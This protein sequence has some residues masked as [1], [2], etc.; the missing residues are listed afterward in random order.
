MTKRLKITKLTTDA[1]YGRSNEYLVQEM[2][3]WVDEAV[4]LCY[5]G[6]AHVSENEC[7]MIVNAWTK[8]LSFSVDG[9]AHVF[10]FELEK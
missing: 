5:E 1:E 10:L 7:F 2:P 8:C 9:E 4:N 6:L 3:V